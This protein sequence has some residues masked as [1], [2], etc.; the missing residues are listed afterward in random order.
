MSDKVGPSKDLSAVGTC[1]DL[2]TLNFC[3]FEGVAMRGYMLVSAA[4]SDLS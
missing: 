4:S 2:G 3:A 1:A